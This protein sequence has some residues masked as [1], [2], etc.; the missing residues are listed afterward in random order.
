M[1]ACVLRVIHCVM[2]SVMF[3]ACLWLLCNM[4]VCLVCG[5]PCDGGWYVC[6]CVFCEVFACFVFK[7][8]SCVL[9]V[10]YNVTLSVLCLLVFE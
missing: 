2:L 5:L 4:F 10:R 1:R 3:C 8:R 7:V 6:L 9:Y